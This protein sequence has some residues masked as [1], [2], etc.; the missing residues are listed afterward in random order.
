MSSVTTQLS[1]TRPP[2]KQVS[3]VSRKKRRAN[4]KSQARAIV[5]ASL[6][7]INRK[8][9]EKPEQRQASREA[10]IREIKERMKKKKAEKAAVK[11][12]TTSTSSKQSGKSAQK[13]VNRGGKR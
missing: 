12:A 11:T 5:G 4:T 1:T 9:L 13:S 6:E 2:Y 8:R 7:V 3:E 10:A